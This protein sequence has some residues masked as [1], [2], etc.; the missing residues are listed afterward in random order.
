MKVSFSEII[1]NSFRMMFKNNWLYVLGAFAIVPLFSIAIF[2]FLSLY[3]YQEYGESYTNVYEEDQINST[4]VQES[5]IS[6]ETYLNLI[7]L[8]IFSIV[9]FIFLGFTWTYLTVYSSNALTYSIGFIS[10]SGDL[11]VTE[12]SLKARKKIL[13]VFGANFISSLFASIILYP[14]FYLFSL[15]DSLIQDDRLLIFGIFGLVTSIFLG[16]VVSSIYYFSL[17][18]LSY[19]ILFG[20]KTFLENIFYSY[21]LAVKYIFENILYTIVQCF[22]IMF[23]VSIGLVSYLVFFGLVTGIVSLGGFVAFLLLQVSNLSS[24]FI[25]IPSFMLIA[26]MVFSATQLIQIL[27]SLNSIFFYSYSYLF[28][29]EILKHE[30]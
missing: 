15:S 24:L 10:E 30:K 6:N 5:G 9:A 23:A 3:S 8:S 20:K 26:F 18:Y 19:L 22:F 16:L 4:N 14:I 11:S 25:S 17:N 29:K 13:Q 28:N 27:K 1:G 21:K 12:T 2:L 7:V